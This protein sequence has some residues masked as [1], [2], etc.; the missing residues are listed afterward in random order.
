[1]SAEAQWLDLSLL[2]HRINAEFMLMTGSRQE[3]GNT[4]LDTVEY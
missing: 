4:S 1:M 2:T 3:A